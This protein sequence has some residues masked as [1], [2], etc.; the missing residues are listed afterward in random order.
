MKDPLGNT[1]LS[2][3]EFLRWGKLGSAISLISSPGRIS[4][5]FPVDAQN[6]SHFLLATIVWKMKKERPP[7]TKKNYGKQTS[8][9]WCLA[10]TH[11]KKYL[12]NWIISPRNGEWTY[13]IY[14]TYLKP[15]IGHVFHTWRLRDIFS[16]RHPVTPKP[17]RCLDNKITSLKHKT[18]NLRRYFLE[19]YD[20]INSK[21]SQQIFAT[22]KAKICLIET[23]GYLRTPRSL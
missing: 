11:L 19:G 1:H 10:S 20:M 23:W 13:K 21:S 4:I 5:N 2:N 22:S 6:R 15:T 14:K 17:R 9:W 8:S 12:S 16:P 3:I 7:T 18:P